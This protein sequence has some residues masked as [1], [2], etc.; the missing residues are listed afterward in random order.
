MPHPPGLLARVA[1]TVEGDY[2]L[3][4]YRY[5]FE[6]ALPGTRPRL[7][8]D[9][10]VTSTTTGAAVCAVEIGYTRPEKLTAYRRAHGI[11]DVRWYDK[12]GG[13][14]IEHL[15]PS[16]TYQVTCEPSGSFD[17]WTATES[18]AI[19]CPV[20]YRAQ[21]DDRDLDAPA[22]ASLPLD[23]DA[24][25]LEEQAASLRAAEDEDARSVAAQ[26]V[27]TVLVTD[28]ASAWAISFCDKCGGPTFDPFV[29]EDCWLDLPDAEALCDD[30][31]S[32][33]FTRRR[34][35]S[36][37][38]CLRY[39]TS[40]DAGALLFGVSPEISDVLGCDGH[41]ADWTPVYSDGVGQLQALRY[42]LADQRPEATP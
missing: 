34:R 8:P 6:K 28:G 30:P 13:L 36:W 26:D 14:H 32:F 22:Q 23:A 17:V 19:E 11:A 4:P 24:D 15:K 10:L 39:A 16:V 12:A 25:V 31:R 33:G 1:K 18:W 35:G 5:A 38:E 20:C 42:R 41:F 27:V 3:G 37:A 2:P 29:A 7:Y 40:I 9:I 21:L